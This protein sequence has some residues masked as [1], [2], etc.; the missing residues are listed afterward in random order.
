MVIILIT[1]FGHYS[2]KWRE[3]LILWHTSSAEVDFGFWCIFK[4]S[5]EFEIS[6]LW[7][8]FGHLNSPSG[9]DFKWNKY[10]INQKYIFK[11]IKLIKP[12]STF[13]L[14]QLY[15]YDVFITIT[16]AKISSI[17]HM[18]LT[19]LKLRLVI[20]K[21]FFNTDLYIWKWKEP[22]PTFF[23]SPIIKQ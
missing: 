5:V 11:E 6:S 10:Q 16:F 18:L 21:A 22:G 1:I 20:L 12:R 8:Q 2:L 15:L 3:T 13:I 4:F 17:L 7:E 14:K 9:I 19:F 23:W